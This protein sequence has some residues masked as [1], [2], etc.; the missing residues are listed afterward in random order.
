MNEAAL[1]KHYHQLYTESIDK[2]QDKGVV[3]DELLDDPSD[4]RRGITLLIRPRDEVKERIRG[5]LQVMQKEEPGQYYYP[6]SD[7]HI[8]LLSVISC[9][10]GFHPEQIDLPS[11]NQLIRFPSG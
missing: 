5:W 1:K 8:T 7:L 9:Y 10:S 3:T 4:D 2:I 11:Y 6:T